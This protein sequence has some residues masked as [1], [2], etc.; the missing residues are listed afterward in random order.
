MWLAAFIMPRFDGVSATT[1]ECPMRRSP[2]PFTDPRMLA[3]WPNTLLIKVTF[4]ELSVMA[5]IHQ[6]RDSLAA[7]G[8]DIVRRAQLGQRIHG[9]PHH[10][11][12]IAR[13]VA[14]GQHIADP[15]AL[16]HRTPA[17]AGGD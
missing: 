16:E 5:L 12:R 6:F 3:S 10:V 8:R 9:R 4:T 7:L 14:L 11:D 13:A 2:K 15:G 17:A 1:T